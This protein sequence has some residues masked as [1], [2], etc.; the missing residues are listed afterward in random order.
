MG[1]DPRVRVRVRAQGSPEAGIGLLVG[2]VEALVIL[3]IMLL[4][5]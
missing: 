3:G 5:W 1:L 4:Q 2:G